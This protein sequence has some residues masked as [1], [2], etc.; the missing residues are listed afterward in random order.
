MFGAI[1]MGG[2]DNEGGDVDMRDVD[3]VVIHIRVQSCIKSCLALRQ[4]QDCLCHES[5][6]KLP[7]VDCLGV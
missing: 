6:G 1:Y 2:L 4:C 7:I 5:D 3:L